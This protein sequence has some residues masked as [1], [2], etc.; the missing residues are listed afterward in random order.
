MSRQ[1]GLDQWIRGMM[2]LQVQK[3]IGPVVMNPV[4]ALPIIPAVRN[5]S[6]E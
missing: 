6:G 3:S 5:S 2:T 4:G 1:V